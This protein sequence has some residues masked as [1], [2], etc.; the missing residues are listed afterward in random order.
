LAQPV[1][2]SRK[3][4]TEHLSKLPF[5]FS[6]DKGLNNSYRIERAVDVHILERIRLEDQGDALLFWNDENDVGGEAE[7]GETQQ[8]GYYKGLLRR[9]HSAGAS[10]EMNVGLFVV[11]RICLQKGWKMW[12]FGAEKHISHSTAGGVGAIIQMSFW[13]NYSETRGLMG[14]QPISSTARAPSSMTT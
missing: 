8:H 9:Q 13:T 10:H 5:D 4:F 3:V 12:A 6:L 11:Q 7:M 1:D 14:D 2:D